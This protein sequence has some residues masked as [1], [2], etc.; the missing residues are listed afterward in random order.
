ML[1][2]YSFERFGLYEIQLGPAVH[3]RPMVRRSSDDGRG[4]ADGRD[5]GMVRVVHHFPFE[6][7]SIPR[8]ERVAHFSSPSVFSRPIRRSA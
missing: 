3:M 2:L 1:G 7:D 5:S 4:E 8:L 6:I